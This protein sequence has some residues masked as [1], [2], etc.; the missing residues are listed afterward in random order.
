MI[1]LCLALEVMYNNDMQIIL[2][3]FS[4]DRSFKNDFP[5]AKHFRSLLS[6]NGSSYSVLK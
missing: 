6:V 1:Y 3:L 2:L 4:L 5:E